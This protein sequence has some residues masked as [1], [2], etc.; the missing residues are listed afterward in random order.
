MT[1]RKKKGTPPRASR[2]RTRAK[3]I[4]AAPTISSDR[5]LLEP[6][7]ASVTARAIADA[8]E[9]RQTASATALRAIL[10]GQPPQSGDSPQVKALIDGAA[11]DDAARLRAVLAEDPNA[12]EQRPSRDELAD[13]WRQDYPYKYKMRRRDYEE[14]KFVLQTELL[15]LQAW[16]DF[17]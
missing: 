11:P 16:V 3:A 5:L 6:T 14:Q 10:K 1:T 17:P 2:A 8:V 4:A 15:K 12:P 9:S 13:N 7:T